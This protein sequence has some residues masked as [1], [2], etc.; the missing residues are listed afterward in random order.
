[1]VLKFSVAKV[2]KQAVRK[3]WKLIYSGHLLVQSQQFRKTRKRYETCPKLTI[4]TPE[5]RE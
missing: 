2:L 1:M 3:V 5:Q 4:K